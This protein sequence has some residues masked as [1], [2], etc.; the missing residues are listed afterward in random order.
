MLLSVIGGAGGS[1][2]L[3]IGPIPTLAVQDTIRL[4]LLRKGP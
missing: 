4:I 3:A 2:A 1:L